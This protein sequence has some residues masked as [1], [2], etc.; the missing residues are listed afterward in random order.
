[1]HRTRGEAERTREG[2]QN[3]NETPSSQ[4]AFVVVE[5]EE[6]ELMEKVQSQH[7]RSS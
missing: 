2:R 6:Y 4:R 5:K 7:K 1:M 3:K